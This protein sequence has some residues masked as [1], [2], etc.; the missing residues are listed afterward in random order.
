MLA[1]QLEPW[2]GLV[3][4]RAHVDTAKRK[5]VERAEKARMTVSGRG[6]RAGDLEEKARAERPFQGSGKGDRPGLPRVG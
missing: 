2:A 6:E 4:V 1:S 3:T 5:A